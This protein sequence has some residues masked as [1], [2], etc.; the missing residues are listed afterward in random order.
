MN[1]WVVEGDGSSTNKEEE[2]VKNTT[3]NISAASLY[4]PWHNIVTTGH[5]ERRLSIILA[6]SLSDVWMF[7]LCLALSVEWTTDHRLKLGSASM[8]AVAALG[9]LTKKRGRSPNDDMR[10]GVKEARVVDAPKSGEAASAPA[11]A[12]AEAS[13]AIS[14]RPLQLVMREAESYSLGSLY[15][16]TVVAVASVESSVIEN[17]WVSNEERVLAAVASETSSVLLPFEVVVQGMESFSTDV[18][19][20]ASTTS[21]AVLKVSSTYLPTATFT[22]A[23]AMNMLAVNT[24]NKDVLT[25]QESFSWLRTLEVSLDYFT[26]DVGRV[27]SPNYS[28]AA[29]A[30]EVKKSLSDARVEDD[31]WRFFGEAAGADGAQAGFHAHG[32]QTVSVREVVSSCRAS[33]LTS[34]TINAT[35]VELRLSSRLS[36]GY[37]L[38]TEQMAPLLRIDGKFVELEAAQTVAATVAAEV[39]GS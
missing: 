25:V 27:F 4:P 36:G 28:F 38:L 5:V 34:I 13:G 1:Q 2:S 17:A 26:L 30:V 37:A 39:G 6:A 35:V 16:A 21:D 9:A 18:D 33:W 11:S 14:T 32:G 29:D 7:Y 8:A 23:A 15:D 19:A 12:T 10:S 3:V 31:A 24:Y 20:T 22:R